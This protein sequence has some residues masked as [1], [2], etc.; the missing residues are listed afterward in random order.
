MGTYSERR[1]I[2]NVVGMVEKR[3]GIKERRDSSQGPIPGVLCLN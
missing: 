2:E 3:K 1:H